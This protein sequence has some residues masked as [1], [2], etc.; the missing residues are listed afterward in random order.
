MHHRSSRF[1]APLS[2]PLFSRSRSGSTWLAASPWLAAASLVGLLVGCEAPGVGD[3]CTPEQIPAGGF[4]ASEAYLETSS[5][6]CRTR[7]CM[8]YRLA[9]IPQFQLPDGSFSCDVAGPDGASCATQEDTE[10][11]VYCTCR[12]DAPQGASATLCDCPED[13][14]SCVEVIDNEKAGLGVRG[15]YCV[16]NGTFEVEG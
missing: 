10:A 5:V 2:A 15:S 9:G 8:V 7:V 1:F 6:Q 14:H 3:P 16:R 4:V 12:C 13:T 11:R